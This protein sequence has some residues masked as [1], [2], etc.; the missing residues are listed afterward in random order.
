MAAVR[1][2]DHR[3]GGPAPEALVA[4][5]KRKSMHQR[6]CSTCGVHAFGRL[7]SE[8][9]EKVVVNVR[10]LDGVDPGALGVQSFDGKSY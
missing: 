10:C 8:G 2:L 3:R 6:F 1:G 9:A 4:V 5:G 7:E